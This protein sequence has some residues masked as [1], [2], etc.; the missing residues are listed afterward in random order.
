[1]MAVDLAVVGFQKQLISSI[2]PRVGIVKVLDCVLLEHVVL[3]VV[4]VFV[5][6][7]SSVA[8]CE[9]VSVS[10]AAVVTALSGNVARVAIL[11]FRVLSAVITALMAAI[12]ASKLNVFLCCFF[13]WECF[14][15]PEPGIAK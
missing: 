1:M 8:V 14:P 11:M 13:F 6:V 4:A 3:V 15:C 5:V 9:L 7:D 12:F 10:S 2:V